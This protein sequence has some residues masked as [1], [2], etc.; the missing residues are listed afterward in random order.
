MTPKKRNVRQVR[1]SGGSLMVT[2]VPGL[3]EDKG[4]EEG[5]HLLQRSLPHKAEDLVRLQAEHPDAIV[6][7]PVADEEVE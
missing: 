3:I 2:F 7:V 5:T 4:I 1:K 6:L